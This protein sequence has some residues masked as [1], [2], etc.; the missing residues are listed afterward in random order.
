[1]LHPLGVA[2]STE[3]VAS[4]FKIELNKFD[5]LKEVDP[6]TYRLEKSVIIGDSIDD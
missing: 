5:S 2:K 4:C 6:G 3:D 1:M